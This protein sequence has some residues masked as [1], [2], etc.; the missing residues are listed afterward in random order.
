M[1][2][3][4]SELV[5]RIM[6]FF[7]VFGPLLSYTPQYLLMDK[8][9]SVGS[10]SNSICI[11][12]LL[13][14]GLRIEFYVLKPY[15]IS[16]FLQSILMLFI[17]G[18]LMYKYFQVEFAEQMKGKYEDLL[19]KKEKYSNS[20]N[21]KREEGH[22]KFR[23]NVVK[24]NEKGDIG[25]DEDSLISVR[26]HDSINESK[27][28]IMLE[29]ADESQKIYHPSDKITKSDLKSEANSNQ[30]RKRS[31]EL[32]HSKKQFEN[33]DTET[34]DSKTEFFDQ[35]EL[36]DRSLG[37]KQEIESISLNNISR[38]SKKNFKVKFLKYA[39]SI[40]IF[41]IFYFVLFLKINAMWF[42]DFTGYVST[43]FES[44]LPMT[45]FLSNYRKK[46]VK[47]LSLFMIGSWFVGDVGKLY[48][49]L[50]NSQPIQFILST[51]NIILF[52]FLILYQF[53]LYSPKRADLVI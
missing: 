23:G 52:D 32:S 50:S 36:K 17:Q 18:S 46:S 31:L 47:S 1:V 15:H 7:N 38:F 28:S 19:Q 10:F 22:L 27:D 35:P 4:I 21:N 44:F 53:R 3:L 13:A 14:H 37:S 12:M 51:I 41:L 9:K 39:G 11:I 5:N 24:E 30:I 16:L 48:F 26:S 8:T 43:S 20:K 25:S 33:D 42:A 34:Q 6:S 45:Q 29:E 49:L 2:S 40:A